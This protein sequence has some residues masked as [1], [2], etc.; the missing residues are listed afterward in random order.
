M[1]TVKAP[2]AY[3]LLYWL[4]RTKTGQTVFGDLWVELKVMAIRYYFGKKAGH[5]LDNRLNAFV[6]E[7]SQLWSKKKD[8]RRA[9][10]V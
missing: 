6:N 7:L 2:D 4:R 5:N 9:V 10:D 8:L 1:E 3:K